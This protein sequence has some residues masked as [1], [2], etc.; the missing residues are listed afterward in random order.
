MASIRP[1]LVV[2]TLVVSVQAAAQIEKPVTWESLLYTDHPLA[3]MIWDSHTGEFVTES[4]LAQRIESAGYLLLGEKHD[5]PDHHI[6]Q[7]K[8]LQHLIRHGQVGRV[9]FEMM[10]SDDQGRLEALPRQRLATL[11]ALK[12]YLQW[13]D[14]AWDWDFYGPL[15]EASYRAQVPIVAANITSTAVG[16]IYA[17]PTP[18]ELIGILDGATMEQLN[19][20]IDESHCGRL[21]ESRFPAMVRIQQARDYAMAQSLVESLGESLGEG[22]DKRADEAG[23]GDTVVLIAGNYHVRQDLG[24]PNYLPAVSDTAQRDEILALSFMEV[25]P[26]EEEPAAYLQRF[27]AVNAYDLIWFTPAVS[28]EDYCASL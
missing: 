22:M 20:D 7:H 3:G 18:P 19:V 21:P 1:L 11:D 23:K 27:G 4:A 26:D 8:V 14:A 10:D 24:V 6:L 28:D 9:A 25:Q 16:R 5:N 13:D 2:L 12:S 17:E 15:I